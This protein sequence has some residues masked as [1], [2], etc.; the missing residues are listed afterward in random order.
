MS[1][2]KR[3]QRKRYLTLI[4]IM[5]VIVLI[6]LIGSV[7]AYN[8]RGSLEEGKIFK[9]KQGGA[10]IYNILNL[11]VARGQEL[12][13]A[14]SHWKEV[15]SESSLAKNGKELC[16]DGWGEEYQ[17]TEQNGDII[18]TSRRYTNHLRKK[19]PELSEEESYL[20]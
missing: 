16:K 1:S 18:V 7:V 11:E 15:V 13:D 14:I 12:S 4:E 20:K 6:G 2:R 19:H 9:T 3:F 10:Q 5:I 8:M 17:V